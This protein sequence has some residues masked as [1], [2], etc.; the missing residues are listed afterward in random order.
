MRARRDRSHG[1]IRTP[2]LVLFGSIALAVGTFLV[3][4][5][6]FGDASPRR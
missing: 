4:M 1:H 5:A 6:I 3:L 2:P